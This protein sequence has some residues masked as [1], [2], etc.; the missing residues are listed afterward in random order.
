MASYGSV[1]NVQFGGTVYH[2]DLG[3]TSDGGLVGYRPGPNHNEFFNDHLISN[4]CEQLRASYP[5]GFQLQDGFQTNSFQQQGNVQGNLQGN[6][7]PPMQHNT[8]PSGFQ[9]GM[10]GGMPGGLQGYQGSLPG[11]LQA[12]GPQA[13]WQPQQPQQHHQQQP[14]YATAPRNP[15]QQQQQ[16][17]QHIPYSYR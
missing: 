9:G 10:M 12:G 1:G 17:Q 3:A 15:R 8:L 16:Q 7:P 13:V 6:M 11:G 14:H 2:E 4:Q 5:G